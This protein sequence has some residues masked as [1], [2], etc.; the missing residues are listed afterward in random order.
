MVPILLL[1]SPEEPM[2][3]PEFGFTTAVTVAAKEGRLVLSPYL[4][5]P[6]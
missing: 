5:R 1:G 3:E 4:K 6:N 2:S